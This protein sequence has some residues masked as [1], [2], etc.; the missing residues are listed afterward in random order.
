M[1]LTTIR[2]DYLNEGITSE[3]QVLLLSKPDDTYF[4]I[5]YKDD[6]DLENYLDYLDEKEKMDAYLKAK[7]DINGD[8]IKYRRFKEEKMD[9]I[10]EFKENI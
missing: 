9:N 8:T 4:G 5:E 10:I 6:A 3:R 2:F 1:K 7:Y